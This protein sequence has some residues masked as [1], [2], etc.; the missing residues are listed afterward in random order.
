MFDMPYSHALCSHCD[1]WV[2]LR[3]LSNCSQTWLLRAHP[4]RNFTWQGK[5]IA[6]MS[7]SANVCG[8][9]R[10]RKETSSFL[11]VNYHLLPMGHRPRRLALGILL[12]F[13]RCQADG[14]AHLSRIRR[15]VEFFVRSRISGI[16]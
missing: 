2:L 3:L 13:S 10:L 5:V 7:T 16:C 11:L 14:R 9:C 8:I 4:G 6:I 1:E 15:E 12:K